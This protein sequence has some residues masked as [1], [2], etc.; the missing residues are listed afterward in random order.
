MT[1]CCKLDYLILFKN[2]QHQP[3]KRTGVL[4]KNFLN[5]KIF[6]TVMKINDT[7]MNWESNEE[8]RNTF[9]KLRY[10]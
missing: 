5:V 10:A 9:L 4:Q 6:T 3:H 2:N 8:A 7:S 1:E